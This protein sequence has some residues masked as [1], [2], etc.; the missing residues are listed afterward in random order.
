MPKALD[1]EQTFDVVL[2]C[3][4]DKPAAERPTFMYRHLNG[5]QWRKLAALSDAFSSAGGGAAALDSIYEGVAIGLVGWRNMT[6][7]ATGKPI[8]FDAEN[9]DLVLNP[10]EADELTAKVMAVGTPSPGEEESSES[11][12]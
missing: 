4:A 3:D 10:H 8:P 1:P 5:R 12:S 11:P 2:D 7:P 9:I 6:D